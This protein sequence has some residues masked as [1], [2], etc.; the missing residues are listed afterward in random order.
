MENWLDT[1]L[2]SLRLCIALVLIR[3]LLTFFL[4]KELEHLVHGKE[5]KI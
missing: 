4:N 2:Y 3:T 5:L 1:V